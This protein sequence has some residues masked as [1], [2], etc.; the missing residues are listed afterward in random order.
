[1]LRMPIVTKNLLYRG[2]YFK[3]WR[4]KTALLWNPDVGQWPPPLRGR[5]IQSRNPGG[6]TENSV[7][8]HMYQP[9]ILKA[10]STTPTEPSSFKGI[11]QTFDGWVLWR[12][13][14]AVS[15]PRGDRTIH[16]CASRSRPA[17]EQ[18][19]KYMLV[20]KIY[21]VIG[22]QGY[23]LLSTSANQLLRKKLRRNIPGRQW[24][25][26]PNTGLLSSQC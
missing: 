6:K 21:G 20:L 22:I 13:V 26:R 24:R 15:G 9:Y 8:W 23:C 18:G 12:E 3:D 10:S 1:M 4:K 25:P 2:F 14:E 7:P 17:Q 16:T 11:S 5:Y 19:D